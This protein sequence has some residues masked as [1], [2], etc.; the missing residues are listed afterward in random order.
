MEVIVQSLHATGSQSKG[1]SQVQPLSL[2]FS[3]L[4]GNNFDDSSHT[5]VGSRDR[6]MYGEEA[7]FGKERPGFSF[8]IV[9]RC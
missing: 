4:A 6:S 7:F 3:D 1:A 2:Q 8:W 5:T 9:S